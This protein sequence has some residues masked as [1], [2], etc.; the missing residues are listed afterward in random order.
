[1]KYRQ[2]TKTTEIVYDIFDLSPQALFDKHGNDWNSWLSRTDALLSASELLNTN[3]GNPPKPKSD[4]PSDRD[5]IEA[6]DYIKIHIVVKML[7]GMTIECLLKAIWLKGGGILAHKG[8][9]RTI[10][11]TKDHDLYS[12]ITKV[13]EKTELGLTNEEMKIL[14]R[15]SFA[16][17]SGRYPIQKSVTGRNPST[18]KMNEKIKWN[19]W[20]IPKDDK[21]FG[22][23]VA[24]LMSFFEKE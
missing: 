10:P 5:Y 11:G 2:K 3:C 1:M 23:I 12:L 6:W 14:S 15:L 22:S 4:P 17:T 13:S 9:Y 24:K 8:K 16:I 7:R 20:A 19:K 21:L 18:P